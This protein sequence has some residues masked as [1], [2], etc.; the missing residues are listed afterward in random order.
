MKSLDKLGISDLVYDRG[1]WPEI[2][3][4]F[5]N[6]TFEDA[7]DEIHESRISVKI[8]DATSRAWLGFLL[9]S[10][11]HGVSFGFQVLIKSEPEDSEFARLVNDWIV[12]HPIVDLKSESGLKA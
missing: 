4:R 5:P 10:G 3:T 2:K 9:D 8:P 12:A 1:A 6:A 7:S 11:W